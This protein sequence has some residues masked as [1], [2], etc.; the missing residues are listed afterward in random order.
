MRTLAPK[1]GL[2][3]GP[4]AEWLR[5]GL[6]ILA[7]RFDS[8]SGLHYPEAEPLTESAPPKSRLKQV[9]L[10]AW[11]LVAL[12]VAGIVALY[13]IPR[14]QTQTPQATTGPVKSS[15]GGPFTLIGADGK[16]FS[17]QALAGKPY[18]IY[19]GFTRCGNIC[20]TTLSRLVRLRREAA[21]D[22]AM[23]IVLV[24]IDPANDGPREVGQYAGLFNAPIIGLTGSQVQIDQVK[25]QYGIFA[26]PSPHPMAGK[27]MMHTATV[28]LFDRDGNFTGTIS[29]EEPDVGALA[30]LKKLVG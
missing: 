30:R 7:R 19:F 16:P 3:G 21:N 27:Q 10:L 8:G 4:M 9:R 13:L 22:Q 15:F 11:L 6:Q 24:T 1:R 17:S 14:E 28:L 18:A 26:Q 25:K 12:A 20:P 2:S 5:R 23:N 29:P